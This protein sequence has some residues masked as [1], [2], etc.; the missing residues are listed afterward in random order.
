QGA[1]IYLNRLLCEADLAIPVGCLRPEPGNPS[2]GKA[3]LWND[4][5]YPAYAD[6]QALEH[7]AP[8]GVPL[9]KGQLAHRHE[10]IDKIAWLLGVQFTAQVVPGAANSALR[11]LVGSPEAVFREGRKLSR[12]AWQREVPQRASLVIA[13]LGGSRSQQT[14]EQL[15]RAL[16]AALR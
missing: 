14:W 1:P 9:T 2:N 11:V 13:G 10:Q 8:I 7:F 6:Q 4:T 15:D 12:S 3:G 16:E 5:L